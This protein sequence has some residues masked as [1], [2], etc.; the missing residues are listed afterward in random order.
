M[1]NPLISVIV[2]IYNVEKYLP[3]CVESIIN[4]E[5]K[6][7][8]I[9][10]VDDGSPDNCPQICDDY[11]KQDSRI[12]VIHKKNGGLSDA[13]NAGMEIATGEYVAFVDSDDWVDLKM[14]EHMMEVA[15]NKNA[16]IVECNVYNAY[17][18]YS[19]KYNVDPY[20][21]YMDNYAIMKAYVKDYNIKTVV[22]NK[23]YKKELLNGIEFELGKYNEDEFF[24]YRVLA[25]A[26][27]YVHL[28]NYYYYYYQRKGS[29][30]GSDFSLKKLDSLEGAINRTMYI[31]EN[32]PD[33]YFYQLKTTTM[34]CVFLYQSLLKNKNMDKEKIGKNK[35]K[36]YRKMLKWSIRDLK[37]AGGSISIYAILSGVSLWACA[38]IRNLFRIGA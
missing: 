15:R 29:I 26:N 38:S 14:F 33:L 7:L 3:R 28:E 32:Y 2:P 24:T 34:L 31:K 4:Q 21:E 36:K 18:S 16:D 6:N 22:W 12:K 11:Q 8:E 27:I 17:D 25:K 1:S 10:L 13:R 35:V 23:V 9:I 37:R 19:E 30:M 5:Y 20:N